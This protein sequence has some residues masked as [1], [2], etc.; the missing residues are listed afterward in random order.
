VEGTVELVAENAVRFSP[1]QN[2]APLQYHIISISK[3]VTDTYGNAM[4]GDSATNNFKTASSPDLDPPLNV[5]FAIDQEYTASTT[6]TLSNLDAAEDG[7]LVEALISENGGAERSFTYTRNLSY[8]FQ[9]TEDGAKSITV[10]LVDSVGNASEPSAARIVTL[11]RT[12]PTGTFAVKNGANQTADYVNS[13]SVTLSSDLA[14]AGTSMVGAQM[15][16]SVN[17]GAN[18]SAWEAYDAAK[19]AALGAGDGTK[20]VQ[21]RVKDIVGNSTMLEDSI[22]LDATPPTFSSFVLNSGAAY[23]TSLTLG[24]A[25]AASDAT[26]G[27]H[28]SAFSADGGATWGSWVA[29]AAADTVTVSAQ[30]ATTI[31]A[32]VRDRALNETTLTDGIFVDSA[33]PTVSAFAVEAGAT[34]ALSAAVTLGQSAS[35][36]NG[37]SGSGVSQ[38]RFSNNGG[39]TWSGWESYAATKA[40]TLLSGDGDKSVSIQVRDAA[41]NVASGSDGITLDTAAPVV[42]SVAI[43][44][45]GDGTNHAAN[46]TSVTVL[47][48][49]TDAAGSP[50]EM[51]YGNDGS[52]WSGWTAYAG[53]YAHTLAAGDGTKTV[54]LQFRDAADPANHVSSGNDTIILDT[55]PPSV[56]SITAPLNAAS[57]S[58][59]VPVAGAATDS[60]SGI[61]KLEFFGNGVSLG[62][63]TSEPY[64]APQ[65][66]RVQKL[67]EDGSYPV[68]AAAYDR[69]GNTTN[70]ATNNVT[71]DNYTATFLTLTSLGSFG[72]G[73][74]SIAA[75]SDFSVIYIAYENL[76]SSSVGVARSTD[77]GANWTAASTISS[78]TRPAIAVDSAGNVHLAHLSGNQIFYK[79][80]T[81]QGMSWA[82]QNQVGM[83][84][85]SSHFPCI[86]VLGTSYV[87]IFYIYQ[88]SN[89][90]RHFV[91]SSGGSSFSMQAN[92]TGSG[93]TWID[94]ACTDAG[95]HLVHRDGTG[96]LSHTRMSPS[97]GSI[98]FGPRTIAEIQV[99]SA[100]SISSRTAGSQIAVIGFGD[101]SGTLKSASSA[102]EGSSWTKN[103]LK[104]N[105]PNANSAIVATLD[106][107]SSPLYYAAYNDYDAGQLSIAKSADAIAWYSYNV[108]AAPASFVPT[109][110]CD[111]QYLYV[112]YHD[113]SAR[114]VKFAKAK[115][116]F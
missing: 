60:G 6:I 7:E 26:S 40:W 94:A 105:C 81:S 52:T 8:D 88:G 57:V 35:D 112:A 42:A 25:L 110:V 91:S 16:Y 90:T 115:I 96:L 41:G 11:D 92:I 21:L 5:V 107:S 66:W 3:T 104:D 20:T 23:S 49:V 68:M 109:A 19:A 59:D 114:R 106:Q 67:A 28:Q 53:S 65:A 43:V 63:D 108:I 39:S 116:N 18:W 98:I 38:M 89:Y 95:L 93:I 71:I 83:D 62:T 102:D 34:Y 100:P 72:G 58:G 111:G 50:I 84:A 27:L 47:S 51:R 113:N 56:G 54:Y 86:E 76:D 30:G 13:T 103:T 48:S 97:S 1:A 29:F 31:A 69:A 61:W 45:T 2:L 70:T 75:N 4:E 33:A 85:H 80:S 73:R 82:I 22:I 24:A 32:K 12:P 77:G 46:T 37:A 101:P 36:P 64:A 10:R 15:Q 17:G 14:D 44:G 55:T 74:A 99:S 9:N 79:K 87:H 78:A